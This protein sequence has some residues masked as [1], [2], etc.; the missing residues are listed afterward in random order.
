MLK[1]HEFI[2]SSIILIN[3]LLNTKMFKAKILNPKMSNEGKSG[4]ISDFWN[5]I[6]IY[7]PIVHFDSLACMHDCMRNMHMHDM[8]HFI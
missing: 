1:A 7:L 4:E 2:N 5:F 3:A 6:L 8:Y